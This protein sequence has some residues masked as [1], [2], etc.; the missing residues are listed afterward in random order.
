MLSRDDL[1]EAAS[2]WIEAMAIGVAIL[3][4]IAR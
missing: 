3:W 4:L 1:K 2:T